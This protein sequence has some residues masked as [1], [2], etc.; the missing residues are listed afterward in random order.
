MDADG[1]AEQTHRE[2]EGFEM[3]VRMVREPSEK[4]LIKEQKSDI[5]CAVFRV[6]P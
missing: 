4:D 2:T 5:M 3:T 1:F 6:R